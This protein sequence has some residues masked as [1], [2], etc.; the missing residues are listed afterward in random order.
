[1]SGEAIDSPGDGRAGGEPWGGGSR[2][3]GGQEIRGQFKNQEREMAGPCGG[4]VSR[5]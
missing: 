1:M 5:L 3:A 4:T 2:D